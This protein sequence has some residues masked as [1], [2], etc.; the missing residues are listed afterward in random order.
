MI[1][2]AYAGPATLN[3]RSDIPTQSATV[4]TVK[5]GARLEIC[6]RLAACF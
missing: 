6:R 5:H 2:E 1:G 3:L 4:V